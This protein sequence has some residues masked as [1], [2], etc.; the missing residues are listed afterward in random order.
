MQV[1]EVDGEIVSYVRETAR[2]VLLTPLDIGGA[3]ELETP[4]TRLWASHY[5]KTIRSI[6]SSTITRPCD[7]TGTSYRP[8]SLE[9]RF[10]LLSGI[11]FDVTSVRLHGTS[12]GLSFS[13][14]LRSV[15]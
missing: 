7:P 11:E 15:C 1:Y 5:A 8:L 6:R 10:L 4:V 3:G 2:A 14:K 12:V 13:R 9:L